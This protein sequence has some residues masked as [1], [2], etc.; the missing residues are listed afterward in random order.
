MVNKRK[1]HPE[2]YGDAGYY[3]EIYEAEKK[4]KKKKDE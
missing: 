1:E 4:A 2:E 3:G